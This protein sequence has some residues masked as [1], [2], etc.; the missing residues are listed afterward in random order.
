[1]TAFR[2]DLEFDRATASIPW[3]TEGGRAKRLDR[4]GWLDVERYI[5]SGRRQGRSRQGPA[6]RVMLAV[7]PVAGEQVP[8]CELAVRIEQGLAVPA[9]GEVGRGKR[10]ESLGRH[11]FPRQTDDVRIAAA[12]GQEERPE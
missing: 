6:E 9:Q 4:I 12:L 7:V 3:K 8:G 11:P 1:M 2:G 10:V 5:G